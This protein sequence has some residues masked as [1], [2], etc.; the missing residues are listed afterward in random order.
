MYQSVIV[1]FR[2]DSTS[3]IVS[4]GN[5]EYQSHQSHVYNKTNPQHAARPSRHGTIYI[6]LLVVSSLSLSLLLLV[7]VV[8]VSLDVQRKVIIIC[9]IISSSSINIMIM[10]VVMNCYMYYTLLYYAILYHTNYFPIL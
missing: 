4:V 2:C 6:I 3:T 9:I 1:E 8:V 5:S 7:V 10:N